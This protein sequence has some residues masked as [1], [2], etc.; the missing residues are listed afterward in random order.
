MMFL[1]HDLF[2]DAQIATPQNFIIDRRGRIRPASER[3]TEYVPCWI[4]H[5]EYVFIR[6]HP[7]LK[8]L[9]S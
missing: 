8:S 4:L 6:V 1:P 9:P 2:R 5:P 7:C 3:I